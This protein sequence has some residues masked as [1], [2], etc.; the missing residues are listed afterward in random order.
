MSRKH[1]LAAV[2]AVALGLAAYASARIW[3]YGTDHVCKL[4][5]FF[6]VARMDVLASSLLLSCIMEQLSLTVINV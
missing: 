1:M 4:L 2:A 3:P 6:N 5:G